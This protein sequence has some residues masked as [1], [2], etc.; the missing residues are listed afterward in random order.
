MKC[1]N[2]ASSIGFVTKGPSAG[3][4]SIADIPEEKKTVLAAPTEEDEDSGPKDE[5]EADV[6]NGEVI[7]IGQ[8]VAYSV[9][10]D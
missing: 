2:K 3:L 5:G 1:P 8:R 10:V 6:K 4:L 7:V 9:L